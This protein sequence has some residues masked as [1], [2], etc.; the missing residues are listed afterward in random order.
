MLSIFAAPLDAAADSAEDSR[1]SADESLSFFKIS[2]VTE[3]G[4]EETGANTSFPVGNSCLP[5][6]DF[7]GIGIDTGADAF[8]D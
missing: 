1:S 4:V 6:L 2:S 3:S 5:E 7:A 8:S